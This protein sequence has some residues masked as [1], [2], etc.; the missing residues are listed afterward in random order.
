MKGLVF[1]IICFLS[2]LVP[3][4]QL[5]HSPS[6]IL[7]DSVVRIRYKQVVNELFKEDEL[8]V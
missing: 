2:T 6:E 3:D 4:A 5:Y 1:T 7:S 8:F